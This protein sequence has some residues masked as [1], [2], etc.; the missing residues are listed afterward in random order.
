V[1]HNDGHSIGR[2]I[3]IKSSWFSALISLAAFINRAQECRRSSTADKR[4]AWFNRPRLT[5]WVGRHRV[6][7]WCL[8]AAQRPR[9]PWTEMA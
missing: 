2:L 8:A 7:R 1:K 4:G 5:A 9:P 6:S 3:H